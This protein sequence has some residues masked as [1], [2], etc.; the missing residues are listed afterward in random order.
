MP[1]KVVIQVLR[2]D[3][4]EEP[5]D[6]ELQPFVIAVQEL[7]VDFISFSGHKMLGPMGIGVLYGKKELLKKMPPFLSGGEMIEYV[8]FD[9]VSYAELPHKFEAGTVNA[10]GAVGLAAAIDYLESIG[11]EA[12]EEREYELTKMALDGISKIPHIRVLGS[13]DAREHHGIITFKVEG[14][15]PHDIA[16]I[17]AHDNVAVRAGHHC[18]EPLHHF[19]EIPSTTRASIMFYNTE[20]EIERLVKSMAGI[21]A[22]TTTLM[23]RFESMAS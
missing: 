4:A 19:L 12:I 3:A 13:K 9:E 1:D 23:M 21:R 11:L 20:E 18:A 16:D 6:H 10:P 5:V 8:T 2:G 15:H 22:S 17:M 14:V 7:D